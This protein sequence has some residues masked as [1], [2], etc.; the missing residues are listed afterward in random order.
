MPVAFEQEFPFGTVKISEHHPG[1]FEVTVKSTYFKPVVQL[2]PVGS[3]ETTILFDAKGHCTKED[4]CPSGFRICCAVCAMDECR[5]YCKELRHHVSEPSD[6]DNYDGPDDSS[7]DEDD[8]DVEVE[9]NN[10]KEVEED[11]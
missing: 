8:N 5:D 3:N 7:P 4:G 1:T 2:A 10:D 11:D 6:C 9:E